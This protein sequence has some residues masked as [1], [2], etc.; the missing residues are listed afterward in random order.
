MKEL[1]NWEQVKAYAILALNHLII[2]PNDID[3]KNISI[4]ID[5]VQRIYKD[6]QVVDLAIKLLKKEQKERRLWE[7]REKKQY[8]KF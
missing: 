7:K 5:L 8:D 4:N 3:L 1:Y 2:S 6:E